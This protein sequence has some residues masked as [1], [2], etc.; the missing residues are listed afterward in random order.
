MPN[1][2]GILKPQMFS[3]MELTI[4]LGD[5]LTVPEEAVI[6]TGTR[7]IVYVD[8]GDGIFEPREVRPASRSNELWRSSAG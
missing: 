5:R 4:K 7:K 2:G 6:D 8:K 1:P 3:N